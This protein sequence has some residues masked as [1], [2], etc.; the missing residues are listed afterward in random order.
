MDAGG[1]LE[2]H[3]GSKHWPKVCAYCGMPVP[4]NA[5]R[6]LVRVPKY[7]TQNGYPSVGDMFYKDMHDKGVCP[8]WGDDCTDEHLICVL[9]DRQEWD[10]DARADNCTM[11][12]DNQHR[13]WIRHG[14]PPLITVDKRGLSCHAGGGSILGRGYHGFLVGGELTDG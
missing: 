12:Y 4:A 5:Q 2:D 14:V 10:M 13:C 6:R 1:K 11:K 3:L 9:P 8:D 7:N